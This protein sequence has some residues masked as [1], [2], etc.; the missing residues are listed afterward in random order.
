MSG[1][2]MKLADIKRIH[3]R[4]YLSRKI[5]I[6][7]ICGVA[8]YAVEHYL[9]IWFAGKGGEVAIGAVLDHLFLEVPVIEEMA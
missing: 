5:I 4:K 9:H 2:H 6:L 3:W 7:A 8:G 1:R